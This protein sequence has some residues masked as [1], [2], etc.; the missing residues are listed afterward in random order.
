MGFQYMNFPLLYIF[1][2][3]HNGTR[4]RKKKASYCLLFSISVE[5]R[6]GYT[7][8]LARKVLFI[9]YFLL[10]CLLDSF[11][12]NFNSFTIFISQSFKTNS[13]NFVNYQII[14][15]AL[16]Y[17]LLHV[18]VSFLYVLISSTILHSFPHHSSFFFSVKLFLLLFSTF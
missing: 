17:L 14:S 16:K 10:E 13:I 2:S 7:V 11:H 4:R 1:E 5:D 9:H 15:L 3:F 8:A 18:L 12:L 6:S